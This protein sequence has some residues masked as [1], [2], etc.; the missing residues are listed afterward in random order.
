VNIALMPRIEDCFYETTCLAHAHP[1]IP[2]GDGDDDHNQKQ[3]QNNNAR[4]SSDQKRTAAT[5]TATTTT[6]SA[7]TNTSTNAP[8]VPKPL[9]PSARDRNP[10]FS[11]LT[12]PNNN[13]ARRTTHGTPAVNSNPAPGS[14]PPP[15]NDG[16]KN[17]NSNNNNTDNNNKDNGKIRNSLG[18]F[19]KMVSQ[20]TA[21]A[22]VEAEADNDNQSISSKSLSSR[23]VANRSHAERS[24]AEQKL[25]EKTQTIHQ[26]DDPPYILSP[27]SMRRRLGHVRQK[28]GGGGG[29]ASNSF[30]NSNN[31][32]LLF[33]MRSINELSLADFSESNDEKKQN[34][35]PTTPNSN[36]NG[37]NN[38]NG[39]G[40]DNDSGLL[41][42]FLNQIPSPAAKQQQQQQQQ[43]NNGS[44]G[45]HDADIANAN[46]NDAR[47]V[48]NGS[49]LT[50]HLTSLSKRST[51]DESQMEKKKLADIV[52]SSPHWE[53]QKLIIKK[54][55][56]KEDYLDDED[57]DDDIHSLTME[58]VAGIDID[59]IG[60][61]IE[62]EKKL[63]F[64][65]GHQ[66]FEIPYPTNSMYDD[67]F[68]TEDELA[69][70]R[71]TAFLEEAGL[72]VDEYM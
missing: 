40:P 36:G 3:K 64:T 8:S 34:H 9:Q 52:K 63:R 58:Q 47:T 69:D 6:I 19:L 59:D 25:A 23:S 60:I 10:Y 26:G 12:T 1:R 27:N 16:R 28:R 38:G 11:P 61:D 51:A 33:N 67:L 56:S 7:T 41:S 70:F 48:M 46:D 22:A 15:P 68:W 17:N 54:E 42:S 45:H 55:D 66:E 24:K 44:H 62:I 31:Q 39:N 53:K 5:T 21:I 72:D 2:H 49:T 50:S 18:A 14:S 13:N 30:S 35:S 32:S 65:D 43:E 4:S 20:N 37:S 57:E 29:D 71:Y